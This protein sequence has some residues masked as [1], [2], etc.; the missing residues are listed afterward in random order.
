MSCN[1]TRPIILLTD[2]GH[3]DTF[4]GVLKGVI[5]SISFGSKVIDLTHD[6]NPQDILQGSFFLAISYSYFPKG[7]VFCVVVDPGVGSDRKSIC[8]ETED[9]YFVGPDNGVLWKAAK[10]NRIKKI[11][12][13]SNIEYFLDS[14]S[15]TF[16][17]RDIFAPVAAHISKGLEDISVLGP[18]L[19]KCVEYELPEVKKNDVS[20]KLHVIHIDRF[21]NASLNITEIQFA[22]FVRNKRFYLTINGVKINKVFSNYSKAV[23]GELFLIPSSSSYMEI[24]LKNSNAAKMIMIKSLDKASL[25]IVD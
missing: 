18:L 16:H 1:E 10:E 17:G 7:S 2:F 20:L 14:I 24:S 6:V 13:L 21:G 12:C 9:Y 8:I 22:Q 25:E 4:V 15:C 3:K 11:V 19:K 23:E 5:A